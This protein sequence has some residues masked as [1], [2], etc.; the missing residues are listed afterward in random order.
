MYDE[1]FCGH[2]G[3]RT[4]FTITAKR[5]YS[6]EKF[7]FYGESEAEVLFLP[8]SSFTVKT[9]LKQC[10]PKMVHDSKGGFPDQVM[11]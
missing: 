6:I 7:S 9:V 11:K 1:R 2:T 10:D 4:I 3:A 8:L 5:A